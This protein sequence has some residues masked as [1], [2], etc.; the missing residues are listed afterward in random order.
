MEDAVEVKKKNKGKQSRHGKRYGLEFK[1]RCVKLRLEGGFPI[2]LLSKKREPVKMLF[3]VGESVSG[4][5]RSWTAERGR[6][7]A[8][9]AEAS[10]TRA[11]EYLEIKKKSP[12]LE[13]SRFPVF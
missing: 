8:A 13:S 6:P 12:F 11:R 9:P 7:G 10:R 3:V 2:S 4:K 1:L 5:G